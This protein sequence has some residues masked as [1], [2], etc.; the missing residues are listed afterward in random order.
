M[1]ADTGEEM[2]TYGVAGTLVKMQFPFPVAE[3]DLI[4]GVTRNHRRL[5]PM[6]KRC[7][8]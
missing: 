5:T 8:L 2:D 6:A 1:K 4:R 7:K 3:G